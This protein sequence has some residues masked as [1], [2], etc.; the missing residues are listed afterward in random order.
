MIAVRIL[1]KVSPFSCVS[2]SWS[3]RDVMTIVCHD[4]G[5][6][7]GVRWDIVVGADPEQTFSCCME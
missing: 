3:G 7:F 5:F 6:W 1:S 2:Q 4:F